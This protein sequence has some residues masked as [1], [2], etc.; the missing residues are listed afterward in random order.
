MHPF[1]ACSLHPCRRGAS[2][3]LTA[4]LSETVEGRDGEAWDALTAQASAYLQRPYLRAMAA[5]LPPGEAFRFAWFH[6]GGRLVGVACF[7]LTRFQGRPLAERLRKR[8]WMPF[9]LNRLGWGDDQ[10]SFRVLVCG[11]PA[12]SGQHGFHFAPGIAPERAMDAL[13]QALAAARADLERFTPIDGI[14]VKD[15]APRD[16]PLGERLDQ[17][18]FAKLNLEP[19]MVL[20]LDPA[21]DSFET[22]L[23]SL[24]SKYRVKARRAYAKSQALTVVDLD[25]ET[26]IHHRDR[27]MELYHAVHRKGDSQLGTLTFPMFLN[28]RRTLGPEFIFR[29]YWLRGELVGFLTGFVRGGILEAHQV[30]LDYQ[31]NPELGIYPRILCDFLRLALERRCAQLNYGRTAT[32]I[33]STLGAEPVPTCCYVHHRHCLPNHVARWVAPRLQPAPS[34]LRRPF[35]REWYEFQAQQPL[36]L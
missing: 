8:P 7:Q 23:E 14:L 30:G 32:E 33:K 10:L 31:L 5:G 29:G 27:L 9:L 12:A 15:L 16:C 22:Y 19:A 20:R 25:S 17:H 35:T 24:T 34:P 3:T 4:R 28:L 13:L 2:A 26:L 21:W 1:R 36:S 18:A 11:N 6:E